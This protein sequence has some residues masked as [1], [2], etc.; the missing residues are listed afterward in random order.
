MN[1]VKAKD[2][3]KVFVA[4]G[5][6]LGLSPVVPGS[7]GALAGL[8]FH[9]AGAWC[10][11]DTLCERVWCLTGAVLFAAVHYALNDWAQ[12]WWRDPDPRHFVHDEIVGYL[13]VPVFMLPQ[14]PMAEWWHMLAGFC[15][16]RI[17]DAIKLPGARW[18]D[19]NVHT[20]HGVLFDDVVSA[21]YTALVLSA[22]LWW[23]K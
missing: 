3:F 12:K 1:G 6:G 19:R 14:T 16:F 17:F 18:I 13:M 10:F 8:A 15:L 2:A 5:F 20:A 11:D 7:F 4:S 23:M 21:A 22:V 9:F